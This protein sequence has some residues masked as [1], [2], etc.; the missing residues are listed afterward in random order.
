[1]HLL[2][3]EKGHDV[4]QTLTQLASEEY[5]NFGLEDE[6]EVTDIAEAPHSRPLSQRDDARG[7]GN[8][9][10]A[11]DNLRISITNTPPS[12]RYPSPRLSRPR[13]RARS[14]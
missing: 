1:M 8:I 11:T 13:K 9:L 3:L 5:E 7:L 2:D 12:R 14:T 10:I 4:S 6:T